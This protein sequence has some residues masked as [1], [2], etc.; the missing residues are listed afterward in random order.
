MQYGQQNQEVRSFPHLRLFTRHT[1]LPV[2]SV[3]LASTS[4]HKPS[5]SKLTLKKLFPYRLGAALIKTKCS[6][7]LITST[8]SHVQNS[9]KTPPSRRR[10]SLTFLKTLTEE[11][12]SCRAQPINDRTKMLPKKRKEKTTTQQITLELNKLISSFNPLTVISTLTTKF[13]KLIW[14]GSTWEFGNTGTEQ[15]LVWPEGQPCPR[16]MYKLTSQAKR[17]L[18]LP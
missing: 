1:C 2:C 6:V 11:Q 17:R 3:C 4:S 9:W 18:Y 15:P 10:L 16:H 12:F 7:Y 13:A 5:L 14:A 8:H